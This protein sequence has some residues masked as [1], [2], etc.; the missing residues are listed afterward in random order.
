MKS[1]FSLLL[2]ALMIPASLLLAQTPAK[3]A[4]AKP[5]SATPKAAPAKPAT[6][7][8]KPAAVKP[9]TPKAAPAKPAPVLASEKERTSYS[10]GVDIGRNLKQQGLDLDPAALA[11]GLKDLLSSQPL[12][13]TDQEMDS[14]IQI[15]RQSVTTKM[16]EKMKVMAEKNRVDG[17]K[18]LA[19]NKAQP[20]V[21]AL[22]SG[23]QYKEITAGDGPTP[24]TTDTVEVNY[25][26]TL[27]DGTEFDTSA[28]NGGPISF[29]VNRVIPGW[30]EA[31]QLMKVGSKWQLFVPADLAY[32]ANSPGPEIPPNSTLVFEVELLKI[33]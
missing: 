13:M 6:T 14:A 22:P 15:L 11:S 20:G 23:L 8:V 5:P 24:K 31:L 26:G 25:R 9:A 7:A 3:P 12:L 10:I 28:K 17:E 19:E 21:V 16:Q 33:K 30:T 27:I 4:P 2:T 32:G 1:I 29:P 18:F